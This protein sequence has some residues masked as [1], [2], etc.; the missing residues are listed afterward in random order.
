MEL[1]Q[2]EALVRDLLTTVD[3][4]DA[5]AF[6][7]FLAPDARFYFGNAEAVVGR[8]NIQ[9]SVSQFFDAIAS[10]S[11]EVERVWS[12]PESVACNGEVDYLRLDGQ[13]VRLPFAVALGLGPNGIGDYRIYMDTTPL[14]A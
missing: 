11:H 2:A 12:T 8:R 3:R 5:T 4:R 7:E 10:L 1:K 14:F 6:V 9:T 13:K